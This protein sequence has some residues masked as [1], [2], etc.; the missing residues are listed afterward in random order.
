MVARLARGYTGEARRLLETHTETIAWD[1]MENGREVRARWEDEWDAVFGLRASLDAI[2]AGTHEWRTARE[3]RSAALLCHWTA[4]YAAAARLFDLAFRREP[5][6]GREPVPLPGW[7]HWLETHPRAALS[8]AAGVGRD[9]KDLDEGAKAALRKRALER[10]REDRDLWR[11]RVAMGRPNYVE[12]ERDR[13]RAWL[14]MPALAVVREPSC[15]EKLPGVER[16]AW[17]DFWNELRW[18]LAELGPR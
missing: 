13:I 16:R 15:L 12:H 5:E 2:L 8:A 1:E 11:E 14:G 7:T 6:L 3:M 10:M 9:A 17:I 4:H 18:R